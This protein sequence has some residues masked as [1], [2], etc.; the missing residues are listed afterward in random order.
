M[1]SILE[2]V[3]RR[4]QSGAAIFAYFTAIGLLFFGYRY[5]ESVANGESKAIVEPFINELITGAWMAALLFPFVARFARRYPI[6]RLRIV[7]RVS[8]HVAAVIVYSAVHTSLLWGLRT[9]LYPLF[10]LPKFNYGIMAARYPME[11][12]HD[13]LAY[14]LMVGILYLFD[15][16]VRAAQLEAKLAQARLENLR[17]QLQPHF[18]FNALNTISSILYEDP[19]RADAMIDRKSTRLNSSHR[20]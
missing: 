11:F 5:L 20:H 18:L 13:A 8:M 10:G 7:S 6:Q 14:S 15:R 1:A 3:R 2:V 12:F 17:L 19:R 16:H 4:I 9:V